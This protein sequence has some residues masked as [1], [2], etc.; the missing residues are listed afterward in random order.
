MRGKKNTDPVEWKW[1]NYFATSILFLVISGLLFGVGS[2]IWFGIRNE[3]DLMKWVGIVS[4]WTFIGGAVFYY[5]LEKKFPDEPAQP[6]V[7]PRPA[8]RHKLWP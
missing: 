5:V 3:P 6:A 8:S 4:A 2:L 7:R 1:S